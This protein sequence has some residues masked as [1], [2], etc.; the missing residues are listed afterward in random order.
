MSSEIC[1][2]IKNKFTA[3]KFLATLA[4]LAFSAQALNLS[5][6]AATEVLLGPTRSVCILEC[7]EY[8]SIISTFDRN[9]P[10]HLLFL[11]NDR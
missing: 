9:R 5:A 1:F 7:H 2:T 11:E 4:A 8:Q 6:D 3:M 10:W